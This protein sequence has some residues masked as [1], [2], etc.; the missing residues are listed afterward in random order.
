MPVQTL[1][2]ALTLSALW[3]LLSGHSEWLI[4]AFGVG[5][6]GLVVWLARRF[7][8]LDQEGHPIHLTGRGIVFFWSWLFWEIAKANLAV[9]RLILSPKMPITPSVIEVEAHEKNELG[10]VIYANAITLTPGTV[11]MVVEGNRIVVHAL[12]RAAAEDL[13]AGEMDRR[14]AALED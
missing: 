1:S 3:L 5:S 12:S 7:E 2:L 11:S 8:V 10:Q 14:V 6:V 9:A 13:L 4:L